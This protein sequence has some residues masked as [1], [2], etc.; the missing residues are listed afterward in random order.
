MLAEAYR[1]TD[2]CAQSHVESVAAAVAELPDLAELC[3]FQQL[4][5]GAAAPDSSAVDTAQV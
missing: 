2:V 5:A 3:S 4:P 1:S